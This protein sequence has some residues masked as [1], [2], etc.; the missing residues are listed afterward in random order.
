MLAMEA[1]LC[2]V[3][4]LAIWL[5][6]VAAGRGRAPMICGISRGTWGLK[7]VMLVHHCI[8]GPLALAG[9]FQ[10]QSIKD[11]L[12]CLG[13]D[14]SEAAGKMLRDP[15]GPSTAA[16]VLTPI[17]LGYMVA[18]LLLIGMW[19]LSGKGGRLEALVMVAHH[20]LSMASWPVALKYDFCAR[21]VLILLAYEVSSIFLVIRW[22][23][24]A[25]DRK[26]G[27][28]YLLN[29]MLFTVS[30]ILLR[31]LGALPQLWAMVFAMPWAADPS[32]FAI[33]WWMPTGSS[34]LILPHL[35]NFFWGTKVV[36]GALA[37]LRRGGSSREEKSDVLRQVSSA[38][39][40]SRLL[41]LRAAE[42]DRRRGP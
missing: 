17:T 4:F 12:F 16:L 18:D 7:V 39:L 8:V 5:L 1:A 35:L 37:L 42:R 40:S 23:L 38:S 34:F 22:M 27:L 3:L 9:I 28:A 19:E 29:G 21:Y 36:K 10:D 24:S 13:F 31:V 6:F 2:A 26:S 14:C 11:A 33:L 25:S 15:N 41:D 20:V 32:D 30:F